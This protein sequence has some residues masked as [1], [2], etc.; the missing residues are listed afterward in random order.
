MTSSGQAT[1]P[2]TVGIDYGTNSVRA[3]VVDVRTGA[4]LGTSV[5]DYPSGE[6]GILLDADDPELARQHPQDY[7]DGLAASVRGALA[8]A[9]TRPGFD[10]SRVIGLGVD[11]TGS[12]PIPVDA[13][14]RP[15]AL[16]ARWRDRPAAHVW[17]W[18]DHTAHAEAAR[19]TA[20][21]EAERPQY[22]AKCGGRYSSEWFWAKI[23][24]C[25]AAD[26]EVFDAAHTWVEHADWIPAVLTGTEHPSRLRRGICAAG[27]KAMYHPDWGGFPD[28]AFLAALDPRLV[29][30]RRS[31]P[32]RAYSVAEAAGTLTSEWAARLGLPAGIPVAVGAFDAHLGAVGSGIREGTLVKIIG[33][34]TCDL[35]IAPMGHGIADIPGL[36]GIV[37]ESVL[38]GAYGLEAGQSAVG[39][40]F[41]WLVDRVRPGGQGHAELTSGA[42]RLAPGE[43]GLL[44]LDWWNG[45]RT[46]LVDQRLTGLMLGMTLYTTPAEMYRALVEATAFGARVIMERYEAYGVPVARVVN[47]GGIAEKNPLIMQI[48]ADVL[49]RPVQISRSAQT[50]ALGAAIAGAVVAGA[51]AGGHA[52]FDAATAAMTGVR[53]EVFTPIPAN[54][55]IYDRLFA[56]YRRV[57]DAFG[58]AGAQGDLFAVMKTLLDV[59]DAA[60]RRAPAGDAHAHGAVDALAAGNA[61]VGGSPFANAAAPAAL[62]G[63]G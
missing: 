31:L 22:L 9:A 33:T 27:H 16:D 46:V 23:L 52:S 61:P 10:A 43:S 12:T 59:R 37:P 19:I 48:Y 25:A 49:Q 34:S 20:V 60:L 55:A 41:A 50:C 21:A 24:R 56:L 11:T 40:I 54:A 15:L 32:E 35:M 42:E 38:P 30:V 8:H 51:G 7:L 2:Y 47:C 1:G 62:G 53:D 14:G 6:R 29:R 13:E 58:V 57:H 63:E 17:L 5:F 44:A 4:E 3:L 28:E 26:A 36:C 45:N 18:K 39:D